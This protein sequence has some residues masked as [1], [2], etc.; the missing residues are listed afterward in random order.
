AS[1]QEPS[2][3]SNFNESVYVNYSRRLSKKGRIL[4][5][6]FNEAFSFGTSD[7]TTDKETRYKKKENNP[8][9]LSQAVSTGSN[10]LSMW[11]QAAYSEPMGKHFYLNFVARGS[12]KR[13]FQRRDFYNK[14]VFADDLSSYGSMNSYEMTATANIKYVRKKINLTAGV[15]FFP[16][17]TVLKFKENPSYSS[18]VEKFMFNVAPNLILS[19]T[20]S[21]RRHLSVRYNGWTASPAL[22]NVL[23]IPSGTDPSYIR[24]GNPDLLQEFV[25]QGTL[26]YDASSVG[27]GWGL[28]ANLTYRNRKNAVCISTD[29]DPETGFRTATPRNIDGNWWINGNFS[30]NKTF[31]NDSFSTANTL[32]AQYDNK[33]SLLYNRTLKYDEVSITRRT[34]L[35]ASSD[36][37]YRNR[38][39]EA[40][41][42]I[43][44]DGTLERS[45]LRSD[46]NQSPFTISGCLS[47]TFTMPWN[48]RLSTDFSYIAPRGFIFND[49]NRDYMLWNASLSQSF[50]K[51]KLTL[52]IEAFDIL[53]QMV[54]MTSSLAS[55]S[56]T[57]TIFN[58]V[59]SYAIIRLIY[60][61]NRAK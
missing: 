44:A 6:S 38:W 23:P 1:S 55:E 59:N 15:S 2:L 17:W 39:L 27:K 41:A 5:L 30:F 8:V 20:P 35:R 37:T 10:N 32:S 54:N 3:S 53:G 22:T 50:L 47:L 18:P 57:S 16:R 25:Q 24:Y 52:R 43:Y 29:Y 4:A 46:L 19:Y 60:R 36:W 12:F 56:R 61:F 34:M 33:A 21:K 28:V 48:M 45:L 51:K 7:W 42:Q 40:V 13:A 9:I 58:G 26:S 31:R 49:L 14:G 11:A